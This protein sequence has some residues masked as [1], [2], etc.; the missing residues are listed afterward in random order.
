MSQAF[1]NDRFTVTSRK[2]NQSVL[3][4]ENALQGP[5]L[6]HS[7]HFFLLVPKDEFHDTIEAIHC[8]ERHNVP[9]PTDYEYY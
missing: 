7:Q 4:A 1:E 9:A 5:L 6:V 3:A 8:I 2:T